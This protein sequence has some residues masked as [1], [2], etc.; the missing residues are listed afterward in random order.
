MDNNL[1]KDI[2]DKITKTCTCKSITRSKIKEAIVNG[3]STYEEVQ[4]TTGAGSGCCKGRKCSE[5]IND[6]IKE[7]N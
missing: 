4:K 2:L 6:L 3:A 1:N 7:L 5:K